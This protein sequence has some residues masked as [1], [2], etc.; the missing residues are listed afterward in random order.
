M[1]RKSRSIRL[2]SMQVCCRIHCISGWA[3]RANSRVGLE[4]PRVESTVRGEVWSGGECGLDTKKKNKKKNKIDFEEDN[5]KTRRN[6]LRVWNLKSRSLN[7]PI[8]T[9]NEQS[10]IDVLSKERENAVIKSYIAKWRHCNIRA[11]TRYLH[12]LFTEAQSKI[13]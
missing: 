9:A 6:R 12:T 10:R 3:R 4:L 1:K 11:M 2:S 7:S 13:E 8:W 5:D